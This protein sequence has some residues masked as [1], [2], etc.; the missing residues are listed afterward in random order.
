[1]EN[2][3]L[4]VKVPI[5]TIL[6]YGGSE[7]ETSIKSL[8]DKGWLLC[9]GTRHKTKSFGNL[10][11]VIQHS[12]GGEG[13]YFYL[14]DCRGMFIRGVDHGQGKDPDASERIEQAP[15]GNKGD[16]VGSIQEDSVGPHR[17][18]IHYGLTRRARDNAQN[19]VPYDLG[20]HKT[21][22][23]TNENAS[24]ETRPKNL[25]LNFIIKYK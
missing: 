8:K 9:D 15:G 4:D 22:S 19:S 21:K 24:K 12:F 2:D 6:M 7:D 18:T 1:M 3:N 11:A 17:H 23:E 20:K 10:F 16:K 5:G 25:Y 14:P 13:N